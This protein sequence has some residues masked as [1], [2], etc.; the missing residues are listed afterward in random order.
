MIQKIRMAGLG[1]EELTFDFGDQS[2]EA[3]FSSHNFLTQGTF[4]IGHFR[5]KE[6]Y[7]LIGRIAHGSLNHRHPQL[8]IKSHSYEL[9]VSIGK[10][11][12]ELS[13]RNKLTPSSDIIYLDFQVDK[14]ALLIEDFAFKLC[15]FVN[16]ILA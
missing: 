11:P 12:V 16:L 3:V 1:W 6:L 4:S 14:F 15:K 13:R 2:V 9:A 5:P 7:I 8:Q 10:A